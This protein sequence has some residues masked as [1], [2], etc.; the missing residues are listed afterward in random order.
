VGSV[1]VNRGIETY[2]YTCTRL[3]CETNPR[4]GDP[5]TYVTNTEGAAQ[6][7]EDL[8]AKAAAVAMGTGQ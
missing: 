4:P 2:N 1:T 3:H 5:S 6:Q 8:G 7:H